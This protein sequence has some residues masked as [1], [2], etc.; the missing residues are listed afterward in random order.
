M[1]SPGA[2]TPQP[3]DNTIP[4]APG[5]PA[6][7]KPVL[8]TTDFSTPDLSAWT[9]FAAYSPPDAIPASWQVN[10][11]VLAQSGLADEEGASTDALLLTNDS[12][13][14]DATVDGYFYSGGGEAAGVVVRYGPDGYYLFKLYA[15]APNTAP[16][17]LLVKVSASGA[18]TTLASSP[19]WPGYA[20]KT[21][22]RLTVTAV[23]SSLTA[24]IDGK[25]AASATDAQFTQ[26]RIG[27]YA[28]ADGTARF[29][30]FRVTGP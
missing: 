2:G 24:M 30:N 28:F 13:F 9:P 22:Y 12:R 17:A 1:T 21:W 18:Q 15:A 29:D 11:G 26:G 20:P 10:N 6:T 23:G 27:F 3:V 19:D 5:L 25:Q 4:P 8:F 14:G 7:D 16:K